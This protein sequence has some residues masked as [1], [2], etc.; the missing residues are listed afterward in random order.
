MKKLLSAVAILAV[1]AGVAPAW[2]VAIDSN[3]KLVV[4][5][6]NTGSPTT[7][8]DTSSGA[9]TIT[10]VG[11][12]K[13][14][15][16]KFNNTA[17]LATA[18]PSGYV[19][20][21]DSA[22]WDIGTGDFAMD[23]FIMFRTK[24]NVH[25]FSFDD[26]P[27]TLDYINTGPT[28]RLQLAGSVIK[29]ESWNPTVNVW[30]HV[31]VTRDGTNVRMFIDGT[32]IGTPTTNSGSIATST[33]AYVGC[34]S[35]GTACADAWFKEVRF[36]NVSRFTADF[37]PTTMQYA[38]DANTLLLLHGDTVASSPIAPAMYFDGTGDWSN[39]PDSNDWNFGT[40]S[41]TVEAWLYMK[42]AGYSVI[43]IHASND[44]SYMA[45]TANNAGTF[46]F[47]ESGT[48]VSFT[49]GT[50]TGN[51][52]YHVAVVRNVN[53]WNLYIDGQSVAST[54][55][56]GTVSNYTG[57]WDIGGSTYNGSLSLQG[58]TN[59]YIKML[60]VSNIARY[61]AAFTPPT[62]PFTSDGNTLLLVK[63]EET[64]GSTSITDSSSYARSITLVGDTKIAYHED[65]RSEI[66]TDS[67][68]TGHKPYSPSGAIGKV[69]FIVPFGLGSG[70]Y[71]G[72][73]DRLTLADSA[74][75]DFGTGN[76]TIETWAWFTANSS[77]VLV[78]VGSA[79]DGTA[80]GVWLRN[81]G[82][83]IE[84]YINSNAYNFAFVPIPNTWYHLALS[85]SG[86]GSN[87]YKGFANGT[88]LAS[89]TAADNITGS[90]EGVTIGK[91][92]TFASGEFN[93]YMDNMKVSNVARY[94]ATFD[95]PTSELTSGRKRSSITF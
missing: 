3:D 10:T 55:N 22:N 13:Q 59:G 30:Y 72:S 79:V 23:F 66:F 93:G 63:A 57:T 62:T 40:G 77:V 68:N 64:N 80:K 76:F 19:Q 7:F 21:P 14:I 6:N 18:S 49:G 51:R 67:G 65:Y 16:Y 44:S 89:N 61:T 74:D 42:S 29:N 2:A 41:F 24:G 34:A 81:T 48:G 60:R 43:S 11:G 92:S 70:F 8:V 32:Q 94:T 78:D 83:N 56:A 45:L 25:L 35:G 39:F 37:T 58:A 15:P 20:I 38:S 84:S 31:A 17:I 85:R 87:L 82:T 26:G 54:T 86:T 36:S 71:D 5:N 1:L 90:T 73:G 28:L 4:Q 46:G 95:P 52:W 53:A 47:S 69:D 50:Q 12:A 91:A 9:K 27:L 75:W 33:G 88:L